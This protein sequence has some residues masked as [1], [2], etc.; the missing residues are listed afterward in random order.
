M[1]RRSAT[2]LVGALGLLAAG[3]LPPSPPPLENGRLPDSLLTTVTPQCRVVNEI[4]PQL[5]ALL[6]A[7]NQQG[8][9]LAPEHTSF[10]PPGVSGPPRVES[11]YRSYEMQVWWRNY[12]CFIGG[13]QYAAVPGTSVHG[14][15][16]A[17]DFEDQGRE[18]SFGAPGYGWLTANAARYGF[19]QPAW[20]RQ[21]S[22][23]AEP[24]HW[25]VP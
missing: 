23:N 4:A 20:A 7:A 25:E 17:V 5:T 2:L 3:C 14:W 12:Y 22:S 13:C 1:R 16:R 19:V 9:A 24:W 8:I 15:G 11:C 21:G 18:L 6:Q 10:L